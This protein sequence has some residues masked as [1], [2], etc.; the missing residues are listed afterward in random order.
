MS[1]RMPPR[2]LPTLTEVVYPKARDVDVQA[3]DQKLEPTF[4]AVPDPMPAASVEPG[5]GPQLASGQPVL[6]DFTQQ[7]TVW[8]ARP[9]DPAP[10]PVLEPAPAAV[11]GAP[12][13]S[14]APVSGVP[15]RQALAQQLIKL[16]QPQLESELRSI[17]MELFEA[18]FSALLPSLQLHI[19]EAVREALDQALPQAPDRNDER[20]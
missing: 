4:D 10:E 3:A 13:F 19:E 5:S 2:Y 9:F 1:S 12:V 17:A 8:D 20:I 15:D 11:S 6:P 16:V 14:H 7:P 18:Q